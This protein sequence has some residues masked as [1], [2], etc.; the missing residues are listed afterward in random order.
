MSGSVARRA[1]RIST[2]ALLCA[3]HAG[4]HAAPVAAPRVFDEAALAA[5]L[6]HIREFDEAMRQGLDHSTA[7]LL[8]RLPRLWHELRR[9]EGRLQHALPA[10]R[11]HLE[12]IERELRERR[13]PPAPA[14]GTVMV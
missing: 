9:L 1:G 14:A 2:L 7:E 4:V 12:A 6:E 11:E 5:L 10:L 13:P 3:L 8:S